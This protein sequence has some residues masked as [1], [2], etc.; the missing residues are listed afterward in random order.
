[1]GNAFDEIPGEEDVYQ[2]FAM[3][4]CKVKR[5]SNDLF[6]F[7]DIHDSAMSMDYNL[8]IIRSRSRTI[9]VDTGIS[10]RAGRERSRPLAFDPLDG[11][12]RIGIDLNEI[13]DVIITHLHY[14]HA[15]N[16]GRFPNA[17]FHIQD[18]EVAFATGRCM[19]DAHHRGPFD[20]EDVVTLVRHTY[21]DRVVFHDG[22]AE[23][24]PGITLHAFPGH[25]AAVQA[26]RVMTNRGWVVLASDASHFY[27]NVLDHRP[28]IITLDSAKTIESYRRLEHLAG[29]IDR[30]IPGHDPK[31]RA[32]YPK[33][34]VGGIELVALH[35][36]PAFCDPQA[37]ARTD[38]YDPAWFDS[39]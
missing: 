33:I 19:C 32:F 27:A 17:R 21:A 10:P 30:L 7:R 1:M 9:L 18:A 3:C 29:G 24:F 8:W 2:V 39:K 4:F 12:S 13:K 37:L 23:L 22:D 20:V 25:S 31:V 35:E 28:C 14:D 15:G 11:L 36:Q 34:S 26:V 6:M 38:N 16:I 5:T